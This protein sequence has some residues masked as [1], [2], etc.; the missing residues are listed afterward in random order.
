MFLKRNNI[1][2]KISKN[3]INKKKNIF[4][5]KAKL[6]L[7]YFNLIILEILDKFDILNGIKA[8][9]MKMNYTHSHTQ[10]THQPKLVCG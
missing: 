8:K 9:Q 5:N 7:L 10:T 1:N 4:A 3:K 2:D 6:D